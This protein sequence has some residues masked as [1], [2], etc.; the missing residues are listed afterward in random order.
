MEE[1]YIEELVQ[2]SARAKSNTYQINEIKN[3]IK[4]LHEENK[5]INK[6]A[7]SVE[8]IAKDINYVKS[9]ISETNNNIKALS[10]RVDRAENAS[11]FDYLQFIKTTVLPALIA[12]G[13]AFLISNLI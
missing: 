11:K 4:I 3:E 6:L 13:A 10:N 12:G 9:D 7:T 2:T 1:K 5:A 8:L